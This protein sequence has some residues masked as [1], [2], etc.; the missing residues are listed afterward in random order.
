MLA[1][2]AYTVP[3][4]QATLYAIWQPWIHDWSDNRA[5]RQTLMN[6]WQVWMDLNEAPAD[7]KQP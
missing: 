1:E 6:P 3:L 2:K 4:P 5:N 7:R